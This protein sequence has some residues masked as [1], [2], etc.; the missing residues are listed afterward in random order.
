MKP[1]DESSSEAFYSVR[2]TFSTDLIKEMRKRSIHVLSQRSKSLSAMNDVN[3]DEITIKKELKAIPLSMKWIKKRELMESKNVGKKEENRYLIILT[4]NGIA[5]L[6]EVS[7]YYLP[8]F[9]FSSYSFTNCLF[10]C[11]FSQ[12]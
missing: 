6:N 1:I 4:T 12:L 5:I 3:D 9:F 8:F 2:E 11:S 10:I 7:D